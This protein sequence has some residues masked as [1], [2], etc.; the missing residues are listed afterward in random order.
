MSN[1]NTNNKE[2]K[3]LQHIPKKTP[4][5]T[6]IKTPL[7]E[8]MNADMFGV[9]ANLPRII[10]L[11]L[12]KVQANPN[13]PRQFFD[14]VS[15]QE[16]ADSI[17]ATG[18]LQPILVKIIQ[19]L[20]G[21][22][23]MYEIVAGERRYRAHKLLGKTTI[24]AVIA[25]GNT[26][27]I[28]IVENVQREDL[29][30]M[31]LAESLD[32]L[33]HTHGYTQDMV[34][35]VIGKARS[36]VTELLSLNKLPE[37]IKAECRTSDIATKSFLIQLAKLEYVAQLVAWER[38]KAGEVGALPGSKPVKVLA[39]EDIGKLGAAGDLPSTKK[40]KRVFHT[41]HHA[42]IIVQADGESLT[43]AQVGL[44]LREASESVKLVL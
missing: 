32:R 34:A 39:V 22:S 24:A 29:K 38:F 14:E 26:D 1:L 7:S 4:S 43:D 6:P 28:A 20:D 15:L 11:D 42:T 40:P 30:P 19:A 21:I 37:A 10:E 2:E 44:A 17:E 41:K 13:Q 35:K 9:S 25:N 31:E 33:M 16:L 27:E 23:G 18:L 3:T 5:K 12:D 36:T 8:R